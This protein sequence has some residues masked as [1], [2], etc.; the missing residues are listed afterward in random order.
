MGK[1]SISKEIRWAVIAHYKQN[2][3]Q[4]EIARLC[5][6]SPY[7]VSTTIRNYRAT[8]GIREKPR[9]GRPRITSA[10]EDNFLFRIARANPNASLSKLKPNWVIGE[11][12]RASKATI[13][14]RLLEFG[15]ESH[16]AIRKPL[17]SV[18]D[19]RRRVKWCIERKNWTHQQ[20]SR[21]IFSDESNFQIVN[22]KTR[23]FVRRFSNEKYNSRFVQKTIQAGG[24]SIGVWGC[25]AGT[26]IGDCKVYSGRMNSILYKETLENA[27]LPSSSRLIPRGKDWQF[28][29]DGAPCHTA[30]SIKEWFAQKKIKKVEWPPRSPDLNPIEHFWAEIDKQ[31][32][33]HQ[34]TSLSQLEQLI[35]KYWRAISKSYCSRLS[36][37]MSKRVRMCIKAKGGYF[38]Y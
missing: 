5:H 15:L 19:R 35:E 25:F 20:W 27:L 2:K 9:S 4:R 36:E 3:S 28:V 17:L 13:S 11:D 24:G 14:R 6:V 34:I 29:Q 22:R 37:S 21:V 32:S 38:K 7:C 31:L 8:G 26:G 10:R 12:K 18:L 33:N 16:K 30:N 1:R 23:P